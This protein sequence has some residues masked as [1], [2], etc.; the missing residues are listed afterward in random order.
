MNKKTKLILQIALLVM[1]I[2]FIVN[3][4]QLFFTWRGAYQHM[5]K[6]HHFGPATE[7][8]TINNFQGRYVLGKYDNWVAVFHL[9]QRYGFF[10]TVRPMV[11]ELVIDPEYD[12]SFQVNDLYFPDNQRYFLVSAYAKN[13]IASLEVEHLGDSPVILEPVTENLY[14]QQWS[15]EN[16]LNNRENIPTVIRG[17]NEQGQMIY[18]EEIE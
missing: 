9:Q 16:V 12:V 17:Y 6:F 11:S 5:E 2:L 8:H 13:S 10:Y 18:E 3:Q 7:V 14:F 4:Q 1:I 15:A